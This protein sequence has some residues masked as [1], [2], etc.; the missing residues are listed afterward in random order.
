M[1]KTRILI[2]DNSK[3]FVQLLVGFFSKQP[4]IEII[5]A[6]YDG[7]QTLKMIEQTKPDILLLDI[8]M[9][10]LDG[11]EVIRYVYEKGIKL[12]IYVISAVENEKI[13]KMAAEYGIMQYFIKPIDLN[14][15]LN[16][17]LE[18]RLG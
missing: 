10:E 7:A 1:S 11:L 6:A 8:I 9:P 3:D 16:A 15:V 2:S 13:N 12:Q 5:G 18:T 17:I 4:D 14:E